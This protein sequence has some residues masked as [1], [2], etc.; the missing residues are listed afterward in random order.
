MSQYG[1]PLGPTDMDTPLPG[2]LGSHGVEWPAL[3]DCW[4]GD[5]DKGSAAHNYLPF[6]ERHIVPAEVHRLTEIGV[7]T[8]GSL[9][10]WAR[11][12]PGAE[13]IGIDN[14][15]Q[16]YVVPSEN[17]PENVVFIEGDAT[18][19]EPWSTDVLI[20]DGS[21]HGDDQL[22]AWERWWPMVSP[23]GWYVIEDLETVWHDEFRDGPGMLSFIGHRTGDA[24]RH[25]SVGTGVAEV[26]AY[27]QILFVKKI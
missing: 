3:V 24:L 19:I 13:I 4:L 1:V 27:E 17:A 15:P 25:R 16:N 26:H 10:M 20:D 7:W 23:G 22:A 12:I 8:G 14:E 6:Y 2:P 18:A 11:W 5:T 21:H 9:R